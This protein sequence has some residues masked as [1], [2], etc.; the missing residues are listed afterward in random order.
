[1]TEGAYRVR[2][3]RALRRLRATLEDSHD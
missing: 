3:L 2:V 1:V